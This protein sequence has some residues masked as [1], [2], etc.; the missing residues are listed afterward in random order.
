MKGKI[1]GTVLMSIAF[2]L[3]G[4]MIFKIIDH[5]YFHS[6]YMNKLL[7]TPDCEYPVPAGYKLVYNE[8]TK[9]YAVRV[10]QWNDSYLYRSRTYGITDMYSS[11][12]HPCVFEDSCSAKGFI[13]EY[14]NQTKPVAGFK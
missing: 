8:T 14:I 4:Y 9:E 5:E 2:L 12:A 13:K 11:I 3:I 7:C 6:K 10:L 1:I